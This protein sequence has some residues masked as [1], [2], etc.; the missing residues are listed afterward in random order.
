[1]FTLVIQS[2]Q[3]H[4]FV[5]DF[6]STD[7]TLVDD[8]IPDYN[9]GFSDKIVMRKGGSGAKNP[10][11]LSTTDSNGNVST[12]FATFSGG[13][14]YKFFN[15]LSY[16]AVTPLD[17]GRRYA[18][19]FDFKT[20]YVNDAYS[21]SVSFKSAMDTGNNLEKGP[22]IGNTSF[23]SNNYHGCYTF[24]PTP[25]SWEHGSYEICLDPEK[26][27][28]YKQISA[29]EAAWRYQATMLTFD[30]PKS[31]NTSIYFYID[32]VTVTEIGGN[33]EVMTSTFNSRESGKETMSFIT[34]GGEEVTLKNVNVIETSVSLTSGAKGISDILFVRGD[35]REYSLLTL[36]NASGKLGFVK[37]GAFR[38]LCDSEGVEFTVTASPIPVAA[39]YDAEKGTVRYVVDGKLAYYTDG[40]KLENTYGTVLVKG[41]D[42]GKVKI[43]LM[44][45]SNAVSIAN[46]AIK[47]LESE[48]PRVIG[49]QTHAYADAVRIVGGIDMLY[50]SKMG[51]IVERGE[52]SIEKL[53][54]KVYTTIQA[55]GETVTA[56]DLECE[57]I[58]MLALTGVD[59][60][61][62]FTVTPVAYVDDVKLEGE[63]V[64]YVV[65]V[66]GGAVSVSKA[67]E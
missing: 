15:S 59:S 30:T 34:F 16:D 50:Y 60:G 2:D 37:D 10:Q 57:Y 9:Y 47:G 3:T 52:S 17:T 38:T 46:M 31:G 67:T 35:E 11:R 49:T 32:N 43:G 54:T 14:R 53:S 33:D 45:D 8:P 44:T 64:T 61:A 19:S 41:G 7:K 12:V 25:E 63:S 56:E 42:S 6:E 48:L 55:G 1:M 5:E 21:F 62:T 29:A 66:S 24:T 26:L 20:N 58:T 28:S 13:S 51:Y 23:S 18:I 39:I 36:D 65:T 4:R 40:T 22:S 27:S